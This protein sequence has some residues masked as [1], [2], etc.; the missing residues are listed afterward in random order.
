M[1]SVGSKLKLALRNL[2]SLPPMPDV[3]QKLLALPLATEAGEMQL[4]ALIEQ[5][6]QLSARII[7]LA[8]VPALGLNRKINCIRDAAML[9]GMQRLKSVSVGIAATSQMLN[10]PK[11]LHFDPHDLWTHSI[12]VSIVMNTLAQ[13]MPKQVRPDENLIFLSGLLHDIGLMTLHYLD[14]EASDELHHQI[15]T[16][17]KRPIYDIEFDLLGLTHGHI[18]AQLA[19]HWHLPPEIIDVVGLHH[20]PRS[21][22][23]NAPHP[24]VAMVSIAERL[25]PDFGMEEHTHDEINDIEWCEL[26]INLG[27]EDELRAVVNE[28]SIQMAQ[29]PEQYEMVMPTT[30]SKFT[31]EALQSTTLATHPPE[32]PLAMPYHEKTFFAAMSTRMRALW[33][34]FV[35]VLH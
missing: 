20:V 24:L 15:R 17:P 30:Q 19:R 33:H 31:T 14:F 12:S 2:K 25:L 9:L 11:S 28:L 18:G 35:R 21:A 1:A 8:N 16:Q 32:S 10:Q 29:L 7:G 34:W 6:P 26:G 5:D 13:A 27:Q 4:L 22:T 23:P 3:A